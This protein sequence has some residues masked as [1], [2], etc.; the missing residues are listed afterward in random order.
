MIN[1]C[2]GVSGGRVSGQ[3]DFRDP[4][5]PALSNHTGRGRITTVDI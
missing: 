2:T 5:D 3:V 1:Y 4:P